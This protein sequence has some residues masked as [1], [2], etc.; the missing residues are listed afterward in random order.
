M[1]KQPWII[2]SGGRR[3]LVREAVSE[4]AAMDAITHARV[5]GSVGHRDVIDKRFVGG[6]EE[7]QADVVEINSDGTERQPYTEAY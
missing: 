7:V 2:E 3:W 5:G 1:N 4:R 6:G